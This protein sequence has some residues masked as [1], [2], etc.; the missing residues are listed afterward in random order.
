M[1]L[2]A[3]SHAFGTDEALVDSTARLEDDRTKK[4]NGD[5]IGADHH[6]VGGAKAEVSGVG[7]ALNCGEHA[8]LVLKEMQAKDIVLCG[9]SY[10]LAMAACLEGHQDC[11]CPGGRKEVARQLAEVTLSLFDEMLSARVSFQAGYAYGLALQ[12]CVC[13]ADKARAS[14]LFMTMLDWEQEHPRSSGV[15]HTSDSINCE[16]NPK[17]MGQTWVADQDELG[18]PTNSVNSGDTTFP[19]RKRVKSEL[20]RPWHLASAVAAHDAA[21][22]WTGAL[23]VWEIA[24][25]QRGVVPRGAGY[26][27][28]LSA[29]AGAGELGVATRLVGEMKTFRV[30]ISASSRRVLVEACKSSAG[31]MEGGGSSGY[32]CELLKVLRGSS[33]L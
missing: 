5:D 13:V 20:V 11:K 33:R 30:N 6:C 29:A 14:S 28:M 3:C 24:V 22:D 15:S 9:H 16:K 19:I 32:A 21:G 4:D 17:I 10:V 7:L 18:R 1:V 8:I 27:A 2:K 26:N 31:G 23:G 12:A 25:N